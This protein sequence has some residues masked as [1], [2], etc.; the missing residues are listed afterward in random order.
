MKSLSGVTANII[1]LL[2]L[3]LPCLVLGQGTFVPLPTF[4]PSMEETPTVSIGTLGQSTL[5]KKYQIEVAYGF[6]AN[7]SNEEY[8]AGGTDTYI[9]YARLRYG[10]LNN[11]NVAID[12]VA[13]VYDYQGLK[14]GLQYSPF[15][16]LVF[17][18]SVGTGISTYESLNFSSLGATLD[19]RLNK[20]ETIGIYASFRALNRFLMD[21]N[22]TIDPA[23]RFGCVGISGFMDSKKRFFMFFELGMTKHLGNMGSFKQEKGYYD[24]YFGLGLSYRLSFKKQ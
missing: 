3:S 23:K 8:G 2:L 16:Y 9:H 10:I 7:G 1:F 11:L 19:F 14:M 17:D 22:S 24:Y 15:K 13:S 21:E 5:I 18:A 12:G 20:S 4:I 6:G